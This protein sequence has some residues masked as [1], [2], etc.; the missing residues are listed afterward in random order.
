MKLGSLLTHPLFRSSLV[1]TICDAANKAVPFF[2][3]PLL[4]YYLLPSDYGLVANF[5]VLTGIIS[6]LLMVSIDG[7]IS[8]NYYKLSR[9]KLKDYVFSALMIC[10][11]S[12]I[13]L[14]V[15]SLI[16]HKWIYNLINIPLEYQLVC[17]LMCILNVFTTINLTLWRLEEKPLYFGIYEI[18]NTL[19]N[20]SLSIIFVVILKWSWQGRISAML[21]TSILYG[22]LSIYLLYKR[23]Y[24]SIKFRKNLFLDALYFGLP[25]VPHLL[26]F[27]LRSGVDRALITKFWGVGEV[28]LYS[29]GF[30]FGTL[31]SFVVGAFNN[32][33]SP[34][35]YKLL[36]DKNS[37]T[38]KINKLKLVKMTYIIIIGLI[39]SGI[40]FMIISKFILKYFFDIL[41]AN[42]EIYIYW[43]IV[44]QVIQ[45]FYILFV[46]YIFFARKTKQLAYITF[47]CAIVHVILSYFFIQHF[48]PIGA[49]YC[50]VLVAIIN[51][52]MVAYL[53]VTVYKMPWN[54]FKQTF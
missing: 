1:Y 28:G 13:V 9:K 54:I 47:S 51:F 23:N 14:V 36:S 38:L 50:S 33:F 29:T 49:A 48:G 12:F 52:F 10:F 30:L 39:I 17:L 8:V 37:T 22:G 11:F 46:N 43:A 4:S 31:I 34:Y 21:L 27:W 7:A 19:L 5:G 35:L 44:S 18:T 6:L 2:I 15:I 3:L 32:A 16:S 45:G 41:Y 26:S 42:A 53:S 40:I 25:L 24:I 20:V